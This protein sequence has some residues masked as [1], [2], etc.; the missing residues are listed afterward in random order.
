MAA[1]KT[2]RIAGSAS[3]GADAV[4]PDPIVRPLRFDPTLG[5][6]KEISSTDALQLGTAIIE[7]VFSKDITVKDLSATNSITAISATLANATFAAGSGDESS[8]GVISNLAAPSNSLDATNKAY[9]DTQLTNALLNAK[10]KDL[11]VDVLEVPIDLSTGGLVIYTNATSQLSQSDVDALDLAI[12]N[13]QSS[14]ATAQQNLPIAQAAYQ[15]ALDGGDPTAISAAEKDLVNAQLALTQATAGLTAANAARDA[16]VEHDFSIGDRVLVNGQSSKVDNGIYVVT[17]PTPNSDGV[18]VGAWT[19]ASDFATGQDV[20]HAVVWVG[21][22]GKSIHANTAWTVL[23][24]AD[25]T[26]SVV[27]V[28]TDEVEFVKAVHSTAVYPGYGLVWSPTEPNYLDVVGVP[29]NFLLDGSSVSSNLTA[30]NI[31]K[32]F[33]S[34]DSG[35]DLH[36]HRKNASFYACSSG[37]SEEFA[38]GKVVAMG[39]N[40][41]VTPADSSAEGGDPWVIGVC[42][43]T[44][45]AMAGGGYK[46]LVVRD[47]ILEIPSEDSPTMDP[48]WL[49]TSGYSQT[50]PPS[51]GYVVKV[52][53]KGMGKFHVQIESRGLMLAAPSYPIA[54]P[55]NT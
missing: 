18:M 55:W 51:S 46:V 45:V 22:Y 32:L 8:K 4:M 9:V 29:L 25:G 2:G 34:T 50:S 38:L 48:A 49:S 28:G 33:D 1:K 27:T 37:S 23:D 10:V 41:L 30:A 17:L 31:A 44:P 7:T 35:S 36:H 15:T 40:G 43:G 19:R 54:Q 13:A 47:G 12:T 14:L 3:R 21:T 53:F 6:F 52:G 39:Q 5:Q 42:A 24:K 16:V 26:P 20:D 11:V